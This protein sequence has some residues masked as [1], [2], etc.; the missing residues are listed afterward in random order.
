MTA[1]AEH[2]AVEQILTAVGPLP[3]GKRPVLVVL[4]GLPGSGKTR[5]ARTLQERTG[6]VVLESDYLRRVL[7]G[8]PTYTQEE[9]R[10]LFGAIHA[11]A[12]RIL[13]RGAVVVLDATN[14]LERE[15]E[16][17][18]EIAERRRAKLVLVRLVAPRWLTHR[19]LRARQAGANREYSEAG[20]P[21]YER[22]RFVQ[23]PIGRDHIVVDTSK[24]ISGAVDRIVEEMEGT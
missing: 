22:M 18:Y 5:L 10:T 13:A 20:I 14:L 19:R 11:A 6:A 2:A 17:L 12:D 7:F 16:P 15:R 24:D 1:D 8:R 23:Q 21:V 9:S 4:V 3:A